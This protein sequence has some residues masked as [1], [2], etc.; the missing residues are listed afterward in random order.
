VHQPKGSCRDA[1]YVILHIMEYARSRDTFKAAANVINWGKR[2]VV[3]IDED[4]R[5][6]FLRI[7]LNLANN[8]Q[9]GCIVTGREVPHRTPYS[10]GSTV[11]LETVK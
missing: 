2:M 7:Q 6:E 1:Y 3:I 9:Q 11:P 4:L 10:I 8:H 5:Q